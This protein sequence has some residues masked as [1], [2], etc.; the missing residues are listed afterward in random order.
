MEEVFGVFVPLGVLCGARLLEERPVEMA[1]R[2]EEGKL[3]PRQVPRIQG[4]RVSVSNAVFVHFWIK[5]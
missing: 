3:G 2:L 1:A 5:H 4:E